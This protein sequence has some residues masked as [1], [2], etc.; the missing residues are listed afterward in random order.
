MR[1][2]SPISVVVASVLLA[3][4]ASTPESIP[5]LEAA[6][7]AV[8]KVEA[9]PR[10]GVAAANISEAR[11]AL[12][13][14]NEL[15]TKEKDIEE[16]KHEA[17]VATANAEIAN[18][19]IMTAQAREELEKGTLERQQVML[20]VRD[21]EAA[22]ARQREQKMQQELK[23]MQARETERGMLLTLGDVLFDTGKSTLKPGAYTT[24]DKLAKVL[25]ES[26][27]RKVLIEGHTDS[28]GSDENNMA[29]SQARA[30][31]VQTALLERGV[32]ASQISA[33][34]KGEGTP[35]ASNDN[36]SGRQRNRRVDM[37]FTQGSGRV[38]SD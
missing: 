24:I 19:K 36:A 14:A 33:V 38:A 22:A 2:Y 17:T 13:R 7:A 12:D 32:Q 25:N 3:A 27:D 20:E 6:R 16:I 15:Q 35:V 29:L 34:G 28:T 26:R 37:I 18:Q 11:K 8:P 9:S 10:A 30:Q 23:D 21:R 5:E 4:C 31:T 1:S